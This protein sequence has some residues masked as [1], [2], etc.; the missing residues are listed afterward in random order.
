L[1]DDVIFY[2]ARGAGSACGKNMMKETI[3]TLGN[4]KKMNYTLCAEMTR[5]EFIKEVTDGLM[6]PPLYLPMNVKMN[7]E[8]YTTFDEV[9]AQGTTPLNTNTFEQIANET[10]A[11]VLDVHNQIDFI[12]GHIPRSIFIGLGSGFAP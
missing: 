5:N 9:V 2:P 6:P 3:D 4:Q 7:R 11:V 12:D 8:G 1:T 10:D